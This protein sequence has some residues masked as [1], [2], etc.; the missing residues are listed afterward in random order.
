VT[1]V[2]GLDDCGINVSL[3]DQQ[4]NIGGG[5]NETPQELMQCHVDQ[6]LNGFLFELNTDAMRLKVDCTIR[7]YIMSYWPGYEVTSLVV[8]SP[9]PNDLAVSLIVTE[10]FNFGFSMESK[11]EAPSVNLENFFAAMEDHEEVLAEERETIDDILFAPI[12]P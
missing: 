8:T 6:I 5:I 7:N 12:S 10:P 2:N 4:A 11:I 1:F 3:Y 9:S